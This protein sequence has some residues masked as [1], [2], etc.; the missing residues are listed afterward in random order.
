[1][2][3]LQTQYYQ[4]NDQYSDG[5]IEETILRIVQEKA[6]WE[7]MP[8]R[9]FPVLYHL[10]QVRENILSWY[11]F[12]AGA[13]VL[14]IGAGPGAITGLLCR[15][16]D[17]VTSVELSMRRAR[18]NY[19]RHKDCGN[20]TLMVGNL[21]DMEF[22]EAYDY[23]ILNGVF[24]YA[25][26]FTAGGDPYGTFL[27]RCA[28]YLKEDGVLLI[29]I[30]NRLGLK[31][32]AGAPEDHT[33]RYMEGLKG[34]PGNASVRTFSRQEWEALLDRCALSWR[35][36]YYPYPDY[37]FPNEIFTSESLQADSFGKNAWNF[38]PLRLE[39]FSEQAMG[40]TLCREGVM[41]CFMNSFLI[42]AG[43]PCAKPSG[44]A[45]EVLY[46]KISSDRDPAFRIQ[47][48][49]RRKG[50]GSKV[51]VKSPLTPEA[52]AHLRR[53]HEREMK[54]L[55]PWAEHAREIRS[56]EPQAEDAGETRALEPQAEDAGE[57]RALELRVEQNREQRP[58]DSS[59][60]AHGGARLLRGELMEDGSCVYPFLTGK[61]LEEMITPDAASIRMACRRLMDQ[62]LQSAVQE[63]FRDTVREGSRDA[64]RDE[65]EF[66][67]LFGTA[68][69][70]RGESLPTGRG[71]EPEAGLHLYPLVS[72]ANIDLIFDNIFPGPDGDVVI[73]GEWITDTP[74]PAAFLLWRAVNELYASRR[75]LERVLPQEKLLKEYGIGAPQRQ[76]FW[77]WA[78]HFE[79]EYVK[80][81]R[82]SDFAMPVRRVDLKDLMW[83]GEDVRLTA[84]LYTDRG[85]G[86]TEEDAIHVDVI[87]E[88]GRYDVSFELER[89]GEV[90][91]LRFDPLEGCA[92]ICDLHCSQ[93]L[94]R[95]MN[96]AGMTRNGTAFLTLD[97]SYKVI[98][99]RIPEKIRITGRVRTKDLRWALEK[100]QELLARSGPQGMLRG[101]RRAAGKVWRR[102]H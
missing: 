16:C 75:E 72:P 39:L 63:G 19:E 81:N 79:K 8:D 69:L 100:S 44:S 54:S 98:C 1:M 73:D 67:R 9:S 11:P 59:G 36:F 78:A 90:K 66:T 31:Y 61:S 3:Q 34:Y 77:K 65:A 33:D 15:R 29:A 86:W 49:I 24:E 21:N 26:S 41:E 12:R 47:T 58:L 95:P 2:A 96:A 40:E 84:S 20:L 42:E 32:F 101:M 85:R 5:G 60:A 27:S 97:P 82:L 92:S 50:D 10:S 45:G 99:G 70:D 6:S 62:I 46:A 52:A 48:V 71:K 88:N 23:V 87:L 28:G 57:T 30:E 51:V 7:T 17:R 68:R 25:G 93:G 53:M 13:S 74:V 35:R 22:P 80:A 76:V 83:S 102:M 37:K 4:G 91:A 14:E 18:I 94:L 56:L 55:G 64:V 38:N 43:R 89:P